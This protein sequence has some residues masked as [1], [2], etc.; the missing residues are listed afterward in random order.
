MRGVTRRPWPACWREG[1]A[2]PST[3]GAGRESVTCWGLGAVPG[4]S[5]ALGELSLYFSIFRHDRFVFHFGGSQPEL[6]K[7]VNGPRLRALCVAAPHT[8]QGAGGV[9]RTRR[10]V[11]GAGGV[12]HP[13]WAGSVAA[14]S[15]CPRWLAARAVCRAG[16]VDPVRPAGSSPSPKPDTVQALLQCPWPASPCRERRGLR[17]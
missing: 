2:F 4:A 1:V 6:W 15:A 8:P 17:G 9:G 3:E 7:E 10:R 12:G 5:H 16:R 11:L 14:G 13:H